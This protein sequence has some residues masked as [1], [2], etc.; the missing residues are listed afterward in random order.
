LARPAREEEF[1]EEQHSADKGEWLADEFFAMHTA[2]I[3]AYRD[4]ILENT[5]YSTQHGVKG[6]EYPKVMVVFDD[7]EANWNQYSFVK[8]LAPGVAGEPTEGQFERGRK[9]AY[10]C[11][12]RAE[13]HLRIL[14]FTPSPEATRDELLAKGLFAKDQ[15]VIAP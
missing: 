10:V 3:F 13:E 7:I 1:D 12:S 6:E 5:P 15:I 11:F 8:L 2:E 4:F 9:L 14:L